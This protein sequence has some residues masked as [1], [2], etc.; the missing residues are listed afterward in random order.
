MISYSDY[1]EKNLHKAFKEATHE[2]GFAFI[3]AAVI[4]FAF[5][6]FKQNETEELWVKRVEKVSKN[7][8]LGVFGKSLPKDLINEATQ[9]IIDTSFIRLNA[10]LTY[11]LTDK[12]I[13]CAIGGPRAYVQLDSTAQSRMK[14]ISEKP[15]DYEVKMAL[16]NPLLD[17][18]KQICGVSE[19][20][21]MVDGVKQ[22]I[23]RE[24]IN[25]AEK[26]FRDE[27]CN[28]NKHDAL[29]ALRKVRVEPQR[30]VE[31][32]FHYTIIKEEEDSEIFHAGYPMDGVRINIFDTAPSKRIVRAR[33]IHRCVLQNHTN[34]SAHGTY[35][36]VLNR[37]IVPTQGFCIYWKNLP[38][39]QPEGNKSAP[40]VVDGAK[41]GVQ[42]A[43]VDGGTAG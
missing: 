35:S 4:W 14:N 33:S 12:K 25:E 17:E 11:T 20:I 37:Y 23:S 9:L 43:A 6:F 21:I 27:L 10:T 28:N 22:Q 31:I 36:F 8:F 18:L 7:V 34:D 13:S 38:P 42:S 39:A 29:Y 3:V 24:E 41:T 15:A 30:E 1:A 26:K 40:T 19:T 32:I 5:E 16:P 2:I